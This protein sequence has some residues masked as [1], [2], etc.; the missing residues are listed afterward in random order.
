MKLSQKRR[1]DG[2]SLAAFQS[3]VWSRFGLAPPSPYTAVGSARSDERR[4]HQTSVVSGPSILYHCLPWRSVA[5]AA[6]TVAEAGAL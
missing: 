2:A 6:F 4:R 3:D 5:W 1:S